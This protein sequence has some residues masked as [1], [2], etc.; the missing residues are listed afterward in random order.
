M[1]WNRS[2]HPMSDTVCDNY[3]PGK[4]QIEEGCSRKFDQKTS[5]ILKHRFRLKVHF[6]F[7]TV[8]ELMENK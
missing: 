6:N 1:S 4:K 8:M 5:N 7:F 2:S 3:R